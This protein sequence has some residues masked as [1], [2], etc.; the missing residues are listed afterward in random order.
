MNIFG[1]DGIRAQVGTSPLNSEIS[2]LAHA[3]ATWAERKLQS[4]KILI[5]HDTRNSCHWIKAEIKSKLL[6]YPNT[7]Y[8]LGILPTPAVFH[9]VSK[10]KLFD[11]AI[12]ITASHN[13]FSDNGIKII[14]QEG[15][16]TEKQ[17]SEIEKILEKKEF[18][19]VNFLN[20]GKEESSLATQEYVKDVSKQ[21]ESNFLQNKKI[22][23]DCA[24][25]ATQQLALQVFSLFGANVTTINANSNGFNINQKCGSTDTSQLQTAVLKNKADFGIAFDGDGDRVTIVNHDGEIKDGDDILVLLSKHPSYKEEKNVVGTIMSNEAISQYFK[26]N[27]INFLRVDVG[28]K[29]V[30]KKIKELN[31]LIGSE[32]SGHI[33]V[34]NFLEC[35]DGIFAALKTLESAILNNNLKLTTIKKFPNLTKNLQIKYKHDLLQEPLKSIINECKSKI[36][37]GRLVIRYS[38]TEPVLRIM[39]EE[40]DLDVAN[41]AMENLIKNLQMY[42]NN[43]LSAPLESF[44]KLPDFTLRSS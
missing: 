25:G 43:E 1:T 2:N 19:S 20:L 23:L 16:L 12:I 33:I 21:F 31:C 4:K 42:L 37:N 27:N 13:P 44:D 17:E 14:T 34:R 30:L 8:D 9:L 6:L 5:A 39:I 24:N 15:K 41:N 40:K 29:N 18:Y 26:E 3:I 7:V 35:S 10:K 38:G 22:I 28:D 36:P 11:L 32:P